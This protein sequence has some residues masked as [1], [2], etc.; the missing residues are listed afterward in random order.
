MKFLNLNDFDFPKGY[1]WLQL[2]QFFHKFPYSFIGL[3][4]HQ[5]LFDSEY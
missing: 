1:I 2:G 3:E 4:K 5:N